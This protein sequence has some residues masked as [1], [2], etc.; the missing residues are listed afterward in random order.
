MNR[1]QRRRLPKAK[2]LHVEIWDR[3][4]PRFFTRFRCANAVQWHVGRLVITHRA[5]WIEHVARSLHPEVF[6]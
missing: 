3:R 6:K 1:D 2:L 5:P 4:M